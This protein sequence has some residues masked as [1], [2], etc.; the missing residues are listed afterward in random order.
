MAPFSS[1]CLAASGVLAASA[2]GPLWLACIAPTGQLGLIATAGLFPMAA[3]LFAGS[4]AGCLCWAAASLLG[5]IL[6][7]DKGV[8][9]LFAVFLGIYPVA[10]GKIE[11]LRCLPKE[12]VWKLA[13]FNAVLTFFW[14]CFRQLLLPQLPQRLSKQTALLYGTGNLVFLAYDFGLSQLCARLKRRG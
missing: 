3:S 5:L 13:F 6:L 11:A 14:F 2:L 7:P 9:L 8:A 10:K 1:R 12:Y 4:A